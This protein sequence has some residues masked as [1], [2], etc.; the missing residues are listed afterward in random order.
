MGAV[1]LNTRP[2]R[3]ERVIKQ[4]AEGTAVLL[5]VDNGRYY[6]LEDVGARVWDLCDGKRSVEEIAAMLG[7]EYAA[8]AETI[9]RDLLEL[10]GDLMNENLVDEGAPAVG[11]AP[12]GR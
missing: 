6:S 5:S 9:Q 7:G 3:R 12:G 11:R 2:R 10:L 8:P 4:E 1:T